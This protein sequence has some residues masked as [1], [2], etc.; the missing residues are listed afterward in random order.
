MGKKPSYT[1]PGH[2]CFLVLD[3]TF[4]YSVPI[5]QPIS[6]IKQSSPI[7]KSPL[8]SL[9]N[10]SFNSGSTCSSLIVLASIGKAEKLCFKYELSHYNMWRPYNDLE[11]EA[12]V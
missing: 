6:L 1:Q 9:P 5:R 2:S 8:I 3:F 7:A 10:I 11:R 12:G 4:F